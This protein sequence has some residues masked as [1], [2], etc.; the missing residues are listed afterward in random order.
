MANDKSPKKVVKPKK[1]Q[2]PKKSP[3]KKAPPKAAKPAVVGTDRERLI[4]FIA[5]A[6]VGDVPQP[7]PPDGSGRYPGHRQWLERLHRD[8]AQ[9]LTQAPG[10]NIDITQGQGRKLFNKLERIRTQTRSDLAQGEGD[11]DFV[12]H[13]I[14]AVAAGARGTRRPGVLTDPIRY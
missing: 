11:P 6:R 12:M 9:A 13:L 7:F 5:N 2:K 4:A 8:V 10:P 1:S 14:Q 3:A